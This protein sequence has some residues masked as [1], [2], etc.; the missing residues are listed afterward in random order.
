MPASVTRIKS[1]VYETHYLFNEETGESRDVQ[2]IKTHAEYAIVEGQQNH[3]R[4]KRHNGLWVEVERG[5]DRTFGLGD[6][7]AEHSRAARAE[8]V[9]T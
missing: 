9:G 3:A 1:R 2:R 6:L 8:A 7:S 4:V 5:D